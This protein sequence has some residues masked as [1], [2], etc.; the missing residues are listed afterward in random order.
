MLVLLVSMV[1]KSLAR[2]AWKA[3]GVLMCAFRVLL[4]MVASE[5]SSFIRSSSS[6]VESSRVKSTGFTDGGEV[7]GGVGFAALHLSLLSVVA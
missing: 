4:G 7:I 2:L 3:V 1:V 5:S 6:S